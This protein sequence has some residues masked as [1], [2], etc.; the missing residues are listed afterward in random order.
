MR[1]LVGYPDKLTRYDD[2]AVR[3]DDPV[4]NAEHAGAARF[5]LA[6]P[7]DRD[8]FYDPITTV[9]GS[10]SNLLVSVVFPAGFMQPPVF[11]P[12]VDAPINFGGFG[13][14]IGHEITHNFDDEGRKFD[15]DGN[16]APWWSDADVTA[17]RA[18]AACFSDEYARFQIEDGEHLDGD[19]T[20]SE[21]IADN[22]GLRLAW[23]ALQP[24]FEGAKIDGFT[25][26]QRFFL[27]WGQIRCENITPEALRA[28]VHGNPHSPGRFRV[29]GVVVNLPEFA[30]AFSCPAGAPMAPANRC[31][32]W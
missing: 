4:G 1:F 18:H 31:T 15:G 27:A 21:N 14:V 20:L 23:D 10:S 24:A 32:L 9:H 25:P 11:D 5:A 30:R 26:A 29:D 28:Q 8:E 2:V 19:L 22:G 7:T 17:Y 16:V 13:G 12:R 6:W 3:R